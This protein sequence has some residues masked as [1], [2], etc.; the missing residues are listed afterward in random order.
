MIRKLY[1]S[2][3]TWNPK[4]VLQTG[5]GEREM[6]WNYFPWFSSILTTFWHNLINKC[7]LKW[8]VNTLSAI[9][10]SNMARMSTNGNEKT[11]SVGL[12]IFFSECAIKKFEPGVWDRVGRQTGNTPIFF[13]FGLT[14]KISLTYDKLI[15]L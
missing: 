4:L 10:P 9:P 8:T 11:W 15:L 5:S 2:V 12:Q 3:P 7:V 6:F 13:F 1:V 14:Y